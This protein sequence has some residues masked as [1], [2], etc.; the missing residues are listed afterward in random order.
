MHKLML[1]FRQPAD[2]V[3]FETRWS[4][5]FVAIAEQMPGLRKV[6]V[7]RIVGGPD[8]ET[9]LH[10]VH[11]LFFDDLDSLRRAMVSP[12]GQAAGHALMAIAPQHVTICFSEH[13]EEARPA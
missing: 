11:E 10:L 3:E 8:Q 7:S 1:L 6:A 12:E 2:V 9:D 5:E 4:N 13:L